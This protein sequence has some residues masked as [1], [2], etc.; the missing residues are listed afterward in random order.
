MLQW[1]S[2]VAKLD[3]LLDSFKYIDGAHDCVTGHLASVLLVRYHHE[4]DR[5]W[6][7]EFV[8]VA[9]D[10]LEFLGKSPQFDIFQ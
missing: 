1:S 8:R 5:I 3:E 6:V 4:V 9:D 2:R 10:L 7:V